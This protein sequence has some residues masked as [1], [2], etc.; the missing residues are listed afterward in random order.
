MGC[1]DGV[2]G[3]GGEEEK[4]FARPSGGRDGEEREPKK[5]KRKFPGRH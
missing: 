1:G 4:G 5:E 3:G 2:I